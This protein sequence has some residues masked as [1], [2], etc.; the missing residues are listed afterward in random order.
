MT[1]P[2]GPTET[3][4]YTFTP[5][6]NGSPVDLAATGGTVLGL[7]LYPCPLPG[8]DPG[9]AAVTMT[10]SRPDGAGGVL[11]DLTVPWGLYQPR[12]RWQPSSTAD[13]V[14]TVMP[15]LPVPTPVALADTGDVCR[16]LSLDIAVWGER[17]RTAIDTAE[18]TLAAQLG[19]NGLSLAC[20]RVTVDNRSVGTVFG[21]GIGLGAGFGAGI[22]LT[23][24]PVLAVLGRV[25]DGYG[26]TVIT[27]VGGPDGPGDPVC[28]PLRQWVRE[29]ALAILREQAAR[30]AGDPSLGR[31]V[32]TLSVQGQSVSWST[33]RTGGAAGLVTVEASPAGAL[34]DRAVLRWRRRRPGLLTGRPG[35]GPGYGDSP[36]AGGGYGGAGYA[37]SQPGDTWQPVGP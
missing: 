24:T 12:V 35:Y 2:A 9:V 26:N 30:A 18:A 31:A 22:G 32:Q 1:A 33:G 20:R 19:R 16:T 21:A 28:A 34:V 7:D 10:V 4:T 23:D 8:T 37:W 3:L 25:S 29:W 17:A 5:Q 36:A 27:Y 11:F 13:A 14:T 15:T 6:G